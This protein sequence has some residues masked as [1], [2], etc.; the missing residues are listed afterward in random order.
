M[1]A[2]ITSLLLPVRV[3]FEAI[4]SFKVHFNLLK[5]PPEVSPVAR[6]ASS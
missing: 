2:R 5:M 4:G 1:S 3:S 6:F